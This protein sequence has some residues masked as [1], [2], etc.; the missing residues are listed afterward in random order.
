MSRECP[1]PGLEPK[2]LNITG[3]RLSDACRLLGV[4]GKA[5]RRAMARGAA[6]AVVIGQTKIVPPDEMKRLLV[7]GLR[8]QVNPGPRDRDPTTGRF[9]RDASP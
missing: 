2:P 9:L 7:E 5:M 1:G 6:R 3:Y 8:P 4:S